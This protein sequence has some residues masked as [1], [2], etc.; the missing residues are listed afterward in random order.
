MRSKDSVK[1]GIKKVAKKYQV[2]S[3]Q[4]AVHE[5][6]E[7]ETERQVK[8]IGRAIEKHAPTKLVLFGTHSWR[9]R[10]GHWPDVSAF[11]H[12]LKDPLIFLHFPGEGAFKNPDGTKCSPF[13]NAFEASCTNRSVTLVSREDYAEARSQELLALQKGRGVTKASSSAPKSAARKITD[14]LGLQTPS[15]ISSQKKKK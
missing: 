8:S 14:F 6:L 13:E 9:F 4:W 5:V 12:L 11:E 10:Q 1:T 7:S 3:D 2:S 15:K